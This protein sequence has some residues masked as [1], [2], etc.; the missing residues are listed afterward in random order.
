MTTCRST[1]WSAIRSP[2]STRSS[3]SATR[4][5][6][7]PTRSSARAAQQRGRRPAAIRWC[8]SRCSKRLAKLEASALDGRARRL[9][10]AA[11]Q[12]PIVS[13]FD[14]ALIVGTVA[15]ASAADVDRMVRAGRAAQP[16]WDALGGEAR[17]RPARPRRRPVRAASRRALLAVHPRGRQDLARR[18][19]RGAR[20]GR[21][22]ALLRQ[23]GAPP[24]QPVR[25]PLPGPT[26]ELNE[27]R[28][29]GRGVFACI[30]PW[31]FPLAIFI[32]PVAAALAAG[33][34]VIAKPAEQTP[35]IGA[36]AIEL[37]HEAGIPDATSSSWCPATARSARR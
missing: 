20:G 11:R 30:S 24:V 10:E 2:S 22:P 19:A 36:L 14:T 4:R 26:G 18:R 23:R 7:C 17:A 27:L 1:S 32:G 5:S 34:A 13:P 21:F 33:N 6:R 3:P 12:A 15:D 31:N 9:A 8:A 28:L 29:H 35:L 25:P 37:M 16:A